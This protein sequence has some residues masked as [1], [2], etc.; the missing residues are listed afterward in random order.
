MVN[1]WKKF[2]VVEVEADI[3]GEINI[4]K[5]RGVLIKTTLTRKS[6]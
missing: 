6:V 2:S 4:D 5:K 1:W 3:S